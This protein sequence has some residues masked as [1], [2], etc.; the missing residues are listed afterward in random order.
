MSAADAIAELFEEHRLALLRR[1]RRVVGAEAD[2]EDAV[3]EVMITLLRAPH[4]L[5]GVERLGGWLLTLVTR[6]CLDLMRSESRRRAR[7]S[8][9]G[10]VELFAGSVQ[11]LALMQRAEV[12][13]F[14]ARQIAALPVEQRAVFV[15]NAL[16]G[17]SYRELSEAWG[18]PMGTLM[19]R[20][21]KAV[22]TLRASLREQGYLG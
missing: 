19:A 9:Q 17:M 18:V 6:R 2:A 8:A 20:K 11:P 7:E 4:L 14:V 15:G 12:C 13:Q 16:D 3:Q 5:A 1:A 10:V 22:D 21:K